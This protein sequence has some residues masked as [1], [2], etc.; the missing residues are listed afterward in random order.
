MVVYTFQTFP[1]IKELEQQFGSVFVFS[2]L[3][4]DMVAFEKVLES[5]PSKVL[6]VALSKQRSREEPITINKFNKGLV[7]RHG[8]KQLSLTL[9]NNFPSA[10]KPTYTFC[11]WTMYHIQN[12]INE[13]RLSTAFTFIHINKADI[14]QLEAVSKQLNS[15]SS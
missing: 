3:K 13:K 12:F 14:G 2:K 4:D 6:G 11:N 5:E 9:A 10:T 7:L 15:I 1:Y 8:A